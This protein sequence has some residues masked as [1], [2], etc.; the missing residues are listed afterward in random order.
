LKV[1][2]DYGFKPIELTI[3]IET[4]EE[5]NE[6]YARLN[7]PVSALKEHVFN[8]SMKLNYQKNI[9]PLFVAIRAECKKHFKED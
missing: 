7:V 9:S 8:N 6:L 4:P 2:V 3:K 1:S 5:L